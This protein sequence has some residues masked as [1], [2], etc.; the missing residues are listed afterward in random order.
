MPDINSNEMNSIGQNISDLINNK[1]EAGTVA[2]ETLEYKEEFYDVSKYKEEIGSFIKRK[3]YEL[4][5]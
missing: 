1:S 2:D 3:R 4:D 5:T